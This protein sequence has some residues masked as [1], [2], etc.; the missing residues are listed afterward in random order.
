MKNVSTTIYSPGDKVWVRNWRNRSDSVKL[1]PLWTGPCEILDRIR[2]SGRYKVALPTGIEDVHMD[3]FKPYL[4]PPE[5]T[6]I[7]FMHLQPRSRLPETDDYVVDEILGHKVEKGIHYWR[8]RWK[9]NGPEE[10]T[11]EPASSFVGFVQQD[12]RR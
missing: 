12:W 1:D 5:G 3:D 10:G 11:W 9:G 4:T 2:H 6:A 8:V 7:P